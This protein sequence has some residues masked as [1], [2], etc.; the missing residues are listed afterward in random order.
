MFPR[1][2][3][4]DNEMGAIGGGNNFTDR[5]LSLRV[6]S[7]TELSDPGKITLPLCASDFSI[8]NED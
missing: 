8:Q 1:R 5:D 7:T 2:D 6:V 3:K 4:Y